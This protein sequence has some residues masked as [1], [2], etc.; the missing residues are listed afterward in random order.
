MRRASGAPRWRGARA[1]RGR[2]VRGA[3]ND[4]RAECGYIEDIHDG[5]GYTGGIIGFTSAT[6][7][8]LDVVRIY[9]RALPGN[10]LAP[11]LPALW[12]EARHHIAGSE[13]RS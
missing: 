5:R 2:G 8:M 11:F 13:R 7:D 10:P 12:R 9:A 6:G 3:R 1:C 4:W